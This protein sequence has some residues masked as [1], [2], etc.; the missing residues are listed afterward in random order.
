MKDEGR[1]LVERALS[2]VN[3]IGTR[4]GLFGKLDEF[5]RFTDDTA[6][7]LKG[8]TLNDADR[9]EILR[10]LN[11]KQREYVDR[12]RQLSNAARELRVR[13][14]ADVGKIS[15]TEDLLFFSRGIVAKYNEAGDIIAIR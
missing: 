8:K 10:Q 14:G 6:G 9:P 4:E 12:L 5:G 2:Y 7:V 11:P 1:N 13:A 15:E 3:E